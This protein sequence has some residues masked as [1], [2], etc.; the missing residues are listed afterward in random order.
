VTSAFRTLASRHAAVN[1]NVPAQ[2]KFHTRELLESW[3]L[4]ISPGKP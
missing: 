4:S 1:S 3:A 2:L